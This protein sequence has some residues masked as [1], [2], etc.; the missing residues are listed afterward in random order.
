MTRVLIAALVA[1]IASILLYG[2][3]GSLVLARKLPLLGAFNALTLAVAIFAGVSFY[4][5]YLSI[6]AVGL[7]VSAGLLFA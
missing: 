4:P 7:A 2:A 1:L 3:L 5:H 6:A